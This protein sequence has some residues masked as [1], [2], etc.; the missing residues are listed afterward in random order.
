MQSEG[1]QDLYQVQGHLPDW[2]GPLFIVGPSRTGSVLLR[3][4]LNGLPNVSLFNETHYFDDFRPRIA[5][6]QSA[7]PSGAA[8]A[9]CRSYHDALTLDGYADLVRQMLGSTSH[10]SPSGHSPADEAT[11]ACDQIFME[12][13][14]RHAGRTGARIWGEKTPR[15]VYRID[16]ILVAFP[17]ARFICTVRDSRAVIASYRDWSRVASQDASDAERQRRINSY[18]PVI[19]AMMWRSAINAACRANARY[20][21]ETVRFVQFETL[22]GDPRNTVMEIAAWLGVP[23]DERC[24]LVAMQN[25][26]VFDKDPASGIDTRPI[27]RWTTALSADEIGVI[28]FSSGELLEMFGYSRRVNSVPWVALGRAGL[29]LPRA[30]LR[31]ARANRTRVSSMRD[32]IGHRIRE[33]F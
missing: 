17:D 25:S 20:G 27:D 21:D 8:E 24:L 28:E 10:P 26:S 11:T 2:S 13:C 15:H 7:G 19:A 33:I 31:A 9:A 18:H 16:E 32:F 23:Y 22:V 30:V 1:P 6:L 14:K 3:D 4:I 5:G 29:S 12:C